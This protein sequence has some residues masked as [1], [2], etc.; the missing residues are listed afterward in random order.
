[1][2]KARAGTAVGQ[3]PRSA[4]SVSK[5][6]GKRQTLKAPEVGPA[7]GKTVIDSYLL[8]TLDVGGKE[9]KLRLNGSSTFF[10]DKPTKPYHVYS[11]PQR[12]FDN[13]PSLGSLTMIATGIAS[14][15][16]PEIGTKVGEFID[17]VK[18]IPFFNAILSV[19]ILLT[20]LSYTANSPDPKVDDSM[21]F[22]LGFKPPATWGLGAV[23]ITGFGFRYAATTPQKP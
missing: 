12:T 10:S 16:S 2:A 9:E 19:E 6:A 14:L 11:M 3:R 22:G 7:G 20:D 23:K 4:T 13:A 8:L 15:A 17:K 21:V 5:P 1:M 18:A